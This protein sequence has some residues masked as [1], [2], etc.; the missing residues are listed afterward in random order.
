MPRPKLYH[1]AAEKREASRKSSAKHYQKHKE[2]IAARRQIQRNEKAIRNRKKTSK[3]SDRDERASTNS[4]AKSGRKV[5]EGQP[6]KPERMSSKQPVNT[7]KTCTA[8]ARRLKSVIE[9]TYGDTKCYK[10][11]LQSVITRFLADE[12]DLDA[13]S[14]FHTQYERYC[15]EFNECKFAMMDCGGSRADIDAIADM[16]AETFLTVSGLT[17]IFGEA[18][19]GS[20]Q[21]ASAYS[22]RLFTFL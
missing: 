3:I 14:E 16:R 6:L 4:R 19:C 18:A 11:F 7:I 8:R 15:I 10:I 2:V 21:L 1:T 13:I 12:L 5:K 20:E 17:D 22:K 9:K